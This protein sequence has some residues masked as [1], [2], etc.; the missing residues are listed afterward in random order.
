[1]LTAG[2]VLAL[3]AAPAAQAVPNTCT[4]TWN[5]AT[6]DW[7][8]PA[9]WDNGLPDTN[10]VVCVNSGHPTLTTTGATVKELQLS[11][12]GTTLT[13]TGTNLY[14]DDPSTTTGRVD[15]LMTM[16]SGAT[17]QVTGLGTDV[18]GGTLANGGTVDMSG[19]G[20]NIL[21]FTTYTNSGTLDVNEDLDLNPEDAATF[22]NTGTVD[23][24]A[25]KTL[26]SVPSTGSMTLDQNAGQITGG[27]G[28][29]FALTGGAIN[30]GGGNVD[31]NVTVGI[32][33]GSIN[34]SGT[35]AAAYSVVGSAGTTL[36]GNVASGKTLNVR[37]GEF[38]SNSA[39][40]VLGA[41]R[42]NNGTILLDSIGSLDDATLDVGA[43]TLTNNGTLHSVASDNGTRNV[44]GA[45]GTLAN[46][47]TGSLILDEDTSIQPT[48]TNAGAVSVAN[49]KSTTLTHSY[50][51]TAG[52]T[53]GGGSLTLPS[54]GSMALQGGVL[55]LGR[56]GAGSTLDGNLNN[57]G[58]DLSPC[59][60]GTVCELRV[61]GDYTQGSLGTLTADVGS[62]NSSDFLLLENGVSNNATVGGTLKINSTGFTPASG[63]LFTL[64]EADGNLTGTFA[65]VTQLGGG[66]RTY[67]LDYHVTPPNVVDSLRLTVVPQFPLTVTNAGNGSGTVSSNPSG[68][69]CGS[70]CT[71]AY[72]TGTPVTLSASPATG[73]TFTGW[74]GE[75]CSG[76]G[77][78]TVTLGQARSVTATFTQID[79][80]GDGWPQLQDCNDHNAAI[81]P[82]A[83]DVPD[84]GI[85]ED[86][87]GADAHASHDTTAPVTSGL[88]VSSSTFRAA[89]SGGSTAAHRPPIGT[90]VRYRLSEPAKVLFTVQR[91]TAGRK[92]GKNCVAPTRG[93]RAKRRCTRYVAVRGSFLQTGRQGA[94]SFKFTG[95]LGGRKLAPGVYRL[96]GVATD[97][98]GN[99]GRAQFV[100]FTIVR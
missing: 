5:G 32:V 64:L 6:A 24:A 7:N 65:T 26:S 40:L 21:R 37:G 88:A 85:D 99:H 17:L 58:G 69:G 94:N 90:T 3:C 55:S 74:S 9:D 95:R 93:N 51:Q 31:P 41:D 87:S 33:G 30:H 57:T 54:G 66:G 28:S 53:S 50:T 59:G 47:S 23:I 79:A 63:N 42:T 89:S 27:A 92:V 52:T 76:T 29:T 2:L 16:G 97:A 96:T 13:V 22:T 1:M 72:D 38:G 15:G 80:D 19:S 12:S 83:T 43:N 45:S 82:G 14:T 11:G 46:T 84:N 25:G 98:A 78:C 86:C 91:E 48:L 44:N 49:D 71:Q 62:G 77:I 35:G 73:S 39:K 60:L 68:I 10:S 4:T 18:Q 81:H 100:R 36:S 20:S 34:P 75:G 61:N 8:T 70:A 67:A 56:T